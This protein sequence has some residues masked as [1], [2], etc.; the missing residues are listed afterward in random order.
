MLHLALVNNL[1]TAIGAAPHV[2]RPNLPASPT[3]YPKTFELDLRP[4]NEQTLKGFIFLER[5]EGLAD[6]DSP[7]LSSGDMHMQRV[8]AR[9]IFF[10][11]PE[12][13]TVGRLYRGIE[14]G[15]RY[16][17]EKYGEESLFIGSPGAQASDYPRLQ[18]LVAVTGLATAV[19][20]IQRIV[21][22]GEGA[23]GEVENGHYAR[24]LRIQREYE[25]LILNDPHFVPSCPVM[26]NPYTHIPGDV[27]DTQKVSVVDNPL[28]VA[29]CNLFD[30]AYELLIQM[31]GR[32]FAR[33]HESEAELR[34]L[35]DLTVGLMVRVLSPLGDAITTLP[36]GPS[37]PGLRA[38]PSFYVP[39][40]VHTP[41]HMRAAWLSWQERLLELCGYC[42]LLETYQSAPAALA[43]IGQTLGRFAGRIADADIGG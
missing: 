15:L 4:F 37:H 25:T 9:D 7:D 2:R 13:Q 18:E 28:S 33:T 21:E 36:A 24:F 22:Q 11:R 19:E 41:P 26:V 30:G 20:A 31:L 23:T 35:A 6:Q 34:L 29:V 40:N 32:F 14:D 38:G 43:R 10:D 42:A 5:P 3:V 12:Y 8:T 17:T 27:S 16:L 39:R 1:L